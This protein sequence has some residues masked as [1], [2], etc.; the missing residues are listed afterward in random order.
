MMVKTR[1]TWRARM[2]AGLVATVMAAQSSL[3]F[4]QT[5]E[6]RAGAR[7]AASE[8]SKAFG[9]SRWADAID[10]FTRAQTLV[11]APPHLL[12]IARAHEKLGQLVKAREAYLQIKRMKLADDAPGAFK[13]AQQS[14]ETELTALEP[15]LPYVTV[16]VQGAGGAQVRVTMDGVQIPAA[17]VGVPR[18]V[19]PGAHK[20]QAFAKDME[21]PVAEVTVAEAAKENV[22]LTLEAKPGAS[23]GAAAGPDAAAGGDDAKK[24]GGGGSNAMKIGGY[25]GLGVG[26]VGL[27]LG[28]VFL[29]QASSKRK[30]A[31]A[32][33]DLPGGKCPDSKAGEIDSL[34]KDANSASTL[35]VVSMV[36]GGIGV[37]AGV[38]LLVLSSSKGSSSAKA[39]K[40][41][42]VV[43]WVGYKS[44]GVL[45]RF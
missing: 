28:T 34:D 37:A 33:C 9:E 43:P 44:A 39:H 2:T 20:F 38:T 41:P 29:L 27:G 45:G 12:Y 17:L 24:D 4:G 22:A 18:P 36:V 40:A 13:E 7:A 8:G 3:A 25:V 14:A 16:N 35:G 42:T 11:K 26:V 30:D 19:D 31:D 32:L 5:D 23:A 10:L 1:S 21:S 15:R 6:E